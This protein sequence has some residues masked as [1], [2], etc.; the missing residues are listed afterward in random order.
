LETDVSTDL[1]KQFY[2]QQ[3]HDYD[4]FDRARLALL[5]RAVRDAD[6]CV[7]GKLVLF[8][9]ARHADKL[10]YSVRFSYR[11]LEYK[12]GLGSGA[13]ARGVAALRKRGYINLG[14]QSTFKL[15]P[16]RAVASE[17]G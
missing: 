8:V 11:D 6:L 12:T 7:Q 3:A 14:P 9:L 1:I 13:V 10:N 15:L 16:L 17:E 2:A 4:I 5:R